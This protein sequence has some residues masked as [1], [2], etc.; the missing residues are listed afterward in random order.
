MLITAGI[1]HIQITSHISS[2][3]NI[4]NFIFMRY[5]PSIEQSEHV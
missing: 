4:K 3:I 1:L 2:V 5:W